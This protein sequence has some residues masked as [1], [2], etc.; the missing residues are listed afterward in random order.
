M[1]GICAVWGRTDQASVAPAL[2]SMIA[3]LSLHSEEEA[4][5]ETAGHAGVGVRSRFLSQQVYANARTLVACDAELY[6]ERELLSYVNTQETGPAPAF[7]DTAVLI[8]KLYERFGAAFI[9]KLRGIFSLVVWDRLETRMVA[10]IDGFGVKRLT[11]Y[12]DDHTILVASQINALARTGKVGSTV[13]P[14][15]LATYVNFGVIL[16][17]ETILAGVHRIEPGTM[18]VADKRKT[19]VEK[20]WDMRYGAGTT[21]DC[22]SLSHQLE[23]TMADSVAAHC[24]DDSF[25]SLGAFLSGGTDSST[26]VGLMSRMH[27]GP[28]NAF[29]IGFEDESFNELDYARTAAREFQAKHYTYLVSPADCFEA[30]P[31]MVRAFDEPFGN[32]SAIP[33]YF[34]AR[35][36]AQEGVTTLL[37]GDGGDELFGGNERYLTDKMFGLYQRVPH[38]LRGRL[39]EPGLAWIPLQ[40]GLVGKARKYIRRSNLPSPQRFFSYDFLCSHALEEVFEPAFQESL[41]SYSILEIPCGHYARVPAAA[42]LDRLMY[43]DVKITLGDSDLPKVTCMSEL[44]GVQTRFPYLDRPVAE[45]SGRVPDRLK[46]N[47]FEKRYLFKQAFRG[48]LPAEII[49][50]KKHG[51]GIPVSRWLKS[52][53]PLRELARDILLSKCAFERGYFRRSFIDKLFHVFE[54]DESTYYGDTLWSFLVLELWHREVVDR[55]A[56]TAV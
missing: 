37:A 46:L 7:S 39:I 16:A 56:V 48:L 25:G 2:A 31:G 44:A 8:A 43:I 12:E 18:L 32:S 45:F 26:V 14:R 15:S 23:R 50:K 41:E 19:R 40:N 49:R 20:Y 22:R 10:A 17:P 9:E 34:C 6:N 53:P 51:F 4:R 55:P 29:S 47:G 30:L 28:V 36:A 21:T 52:Y 1:S 27:R 33:T 3:G 38:F 35:L 54:N 42:H 24:K 11:Y 5:Q 13:N